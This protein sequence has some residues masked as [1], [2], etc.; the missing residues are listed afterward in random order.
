MK[1]PQL[2]SVV[3]FIDSSLVINAVDNKVYLLSKTLPKDTDIE[4]RALLADIAQ[5]ANRTELALMVSS[6]I[7]ELFEMLSGYVKQSSCELEIV[8]N[9]LG[10]NDFRIHL[11]VPDTF[12]RGYSEALRIHAQNYV[13]TSVVRKWLYSVLPAMAE[14]YD[15]R[16][17][18]EYDSISSL[19]QS[20]TRM[21][22]IKP[23]VL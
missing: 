23:T 22:S 3:L 16:L 17:L 9:D 4:L 11:T 20:R 7:S 14:Q 15:A 18:E 8:D 21:P 2:H 19:M 6:S 10:I 5:E 12:P 1:K 13:V